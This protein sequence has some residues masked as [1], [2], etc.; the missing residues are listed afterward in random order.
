MDA[1]RRS[2][3]RAQLAKPLPPQPTSANPTLTPGA[4]PPPLEVQLGALD[5]KLE[6]LIRML[7]GPGDDH[8]GTRFLL[9]SEVRRVVAAYFGI[10]EADLDRLDR[11]PR[12]ARI[13]QIAYFL[14][15]SHTTRSLIEIGRS[16]ERD[17]TTILHGARKIAIRRKRDADLNCDVSKLE[18]R[19]AEILA[20][21]N[22]A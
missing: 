3:Q 2:L 22:A 14:C 18:A 10:E 11:T 9:L 15:R 21:R 13:R 1:F 17:H 12:L 6:Q 19:L 16:F 7:R 4:P 8:G 5:R 20:H